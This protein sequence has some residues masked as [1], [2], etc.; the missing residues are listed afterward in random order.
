MRVAARWL[1]WF[2]CLPTDVNQGR[3]LRTKPWKIEDALSTED[4]ACPA[5]RDLDRACPR[6]SPNSWTGW[7][8]GLI[9][10]LSLARVW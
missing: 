1:P 8:P 5:P 3:D 9:E 2:T 6:C 10:L 7:H 4:F